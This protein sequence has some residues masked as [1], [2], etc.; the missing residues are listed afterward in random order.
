MPSRSFT[1]SV[2][3]MR[4]V[5][6]LR[7]SGALATRPARLTLFMVVRS[8]V[9]SGGLPAGDTEERR[10]LADH[11]GREAGGEPQEGAGAGSRVAAT[12][13]TGGGCDRPA[14]AAGVTGTAGRLL[15]LTGVQ[16]PPDSA[17]RQAQ[18]LPSGARSGPATASS[19]GFEE[20]TGEAGAVRPGEDEAARRPFT[21]LQGQL[22][23]RV[24][25][26]RPAP[27]R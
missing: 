18:R 17:N 5:T 4:V 22:R 10:A 23:G 19:P 11:T 1:R 16:D 9:G 21:E 13:A 25:R 8:L 6:S 3:T 2:A 20:A 15:D 7:V 27:W 24:R 14:L 12:R 26:L